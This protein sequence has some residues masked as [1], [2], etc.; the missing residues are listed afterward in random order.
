VPCD[1]C[2]QDALEFYTTA[3]L[4]TIE[5]CSLSRTRQTR[6]NAILNAENGVKHK[7][8]A[9]KG[10]THRFEVR[11][12][13]YPTRFVELYWR[14]G[15]WRCVPCGG[16]D[17]NKPC[18]HLWATWLHLGIVTP[19]PTSPQFPAKIVDQAAYDLSRRRHDE[20]EPRLVRDL[21]LTMS[22]PAVNEKGPDPV[23][24]KDLM[25]G[26]FAYVW[27]KAG[28]RDAES[29][30]GA[31]HD[32]G[33]VEQTYAYSY[34]SEYMGREDTLQKV[35]RLI[36]ISAVTTAAFA[37]S[38]GSDGTGIQRLNWSPWGQDA[39]TKH[40]KQEQRR[41]MKAYNRAVKEWCRE[42]K[43]NQKFGLPAPPEPEHPKIKARRTADE[44]RG[45]YEKVMSAHAVEVERCKKAGVPPPPRPRVA[46]PPKA[47]GYMTAIPWYFYETNMVGA[48]V[49][50]PR[51]PIEYEEGDDEG[52]DDDGLWNAENPYF[53][54][55]LDLLRPHFPQLKQ[56][57]ADGGLYKFNHYLYGTCYGI[58]MQ[59][60]H[61][62]SF[63]PGA[64]DGRSG[65]AR[66]AAAEA[67]ARYQADP[68]KHYKDYHKRSHQEGCQHGVKRTT[69]PGLRTHKQTQQLVECALKF[70]VWNIR[71]LN[72]HVHARSELAWYPDF[73]H[74]AV[75]VD[76]EAWRSVEERSQRFMGDNAAD[77]ILRESGY[78]DDLAEGAAAPG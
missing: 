27:C 45:E 32:M 11:D 66:K 8:S 36:L 78:F 63:K 60:P 53:L 7:Q 22:E 18:L 2:I 71:Q 55:M 35:M 12:P 34:I 52:E 50:R 49:I 62:K 17:P 76:G 59:I 74:A 29:K 6:V 73:A 3:G 4:P 69:G 14:R 42:V 51:S 15:Q 38:G 72:Y 31:W 1:Q 70:L 57:R 48:L 41:K 19:A 37:F 39:A 75:T 54:G 65:K 33:F 21:L 68:M 13:E 61:S 44:I 67:F 77:L 23:S 10:T 56:V 5:F 26:A 64:G 43:R 9:N 20:L 24:E 47:R 25:M 46:E 40:Y 30:L 28:M 58:D 16:H